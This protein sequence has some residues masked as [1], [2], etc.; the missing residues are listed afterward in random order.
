MPLAPLGFSDDGRQNLPILG[1]SSGDPGDPPT[2]DPALSDD[3]GTATV[4]I[5]HEE[6]SR[7]FAREKDQGRRAGVR[8]LLGNLGFDSA[9]ALTEFI[10]SQRQAEQERKDAE[11]A[12]LSEVERR[13]QTAAERERQAEE[14][15]SAAVT[16]ERDA[17]RRALLVGLGATGNDLDDAVL[18]LGRAAD[19]DADTDA[20]TRAAED[21]KQRRPELFGQ[22][23]PPTPPLA[24]PSGSPSGGIPPRS[25]TTPARAGSLGLD[26][27]RRRGHLKN[28]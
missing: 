13:E 27:A 28:T 7:R 3:A 18:L 4:T 20:L 23:Q 9:K 6:L 5:P 24:P 21:L 19:L 14:R 2:G 22:Q 17:A 15:E 12:Q 1:A 8:D 16:R 10:D 11:Q 26:I 25:G